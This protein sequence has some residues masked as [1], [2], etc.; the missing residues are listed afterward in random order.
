MSN[1]KVKEVYHCKVYRTVRN[2]TRIWFLYLRNA[3][4]AIQFIGS[5]RHIAGRRTKKVVLPAAATERLLAPR[6][7]ETGRWVAVSAAVMEW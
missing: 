2:I 4:F 7:E 3:M 1:L 5:K 6:A